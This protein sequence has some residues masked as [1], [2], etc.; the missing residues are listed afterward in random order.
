MKNTIVAPVGTNIDAL[1]IAIKEFATEKVILISP[2]SHLAKAESAA[3]DLERFHIPVDIIRIKS[4][5]WDEIFRVISQ[6]SKTE[7]NLLINVATGDGNMQCAA[8]SAAFVNGIKAM[9]VEDN[10][11]MMLPVMKF[12]YY[13]MISDRKMAIVKILFHEKDCC[14]SL[15]QLSQKAKMSLPLVSYHINGTPK[16][17]G[18]KSMGLVETEEEKGR[19]IVKLS[20]L[21][22]MLVNGYVT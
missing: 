8:T 17:E 14:S 3:K 22:R 5:I 11:P 21:G 4:N 16:S 15:E 2:E 19:V 7:K 6:I 10:K 18:L 13:K 20:P 1:F 12:S 9:A